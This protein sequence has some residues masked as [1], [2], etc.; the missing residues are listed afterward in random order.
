MTTPSSPDPTLPTD[1]DSRM[2][3]LLV[4]EIMRRLED[5]AKAALMGPA[6]FRE[7]R[8]LC[9]SNSVS[10]ASIRKGDFGQVAQRVAEEFP[11]DGDGN[12]VAIGGSR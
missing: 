1:F 12:V 10:F 6:D 3:K 5:P 2:L 7:I 4:A 11:F 9:E 8:M